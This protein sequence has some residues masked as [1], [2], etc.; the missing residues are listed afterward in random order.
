MHATHSGATESHIRVGVIR[1]STSGDLEWNVGLE[2]LNGTSCYHFHR[3]TFGPY[4]YHESGHTRAVVTAHPDGSASIAAPFH[5]NLSVG[6]VVVEPRASQT[7]GLA[8]ARSR[9]TGR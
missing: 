5:S 4:G 9:A 7:I 6:G 2:P 3:G 8:M 1:L